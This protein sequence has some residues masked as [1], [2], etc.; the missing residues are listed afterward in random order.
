MKYEVRNTSL[1][2]PCSFQIT[3]DEA[4]QIKLARD[5]LITLIELETL[6][7][8]VLT[9]YLEI[10]NTIASEAI[11]GMARS[12][13]DFY[14]YRLV[15]IEMGR[16][17]MNLLTTTRAFLDQSPPLLSKLSD[18]EKK[19]YAEKFDLE[20]SRAYDAEFSYRLL[21]GLR[22]YAQHHSMPVHGS[23]FNNR[24]L[25]ES[26]HLE[27]SVSIYI[28]ID[29]LLA[30]KKIKAKL[31]DDLNKRMSKKNQI[32]LVESIRVYVECLGGLVSVVRKATKS[33]AD[34]SNERVSAAHDRLAEMSDQ[35]V[36]AALD[37]IDD[38][39]SRVSRMHLNTETGA[40]LKSLRSR[41]GV[42]TNLRRRIIS[43][44]FVP[45]PVV[46]VTN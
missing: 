5:D 8:C 20:R 10:E 1:S 7:H 18:N 23:E 45:T 28:Q 2:D 42:A 19:R 40:F 31:K 25:K 38:S 29:K 16:R 34:S 11:F 12:R 44:Q 15:N 3:E 46:E 4:D 13:I 14:E 27:H 22:N 33:L 21:E 37:G 9:N 32:S 26:D 17:F 24:W 41:N 35:S 30:D 43:N 36:F 39:G 6:W